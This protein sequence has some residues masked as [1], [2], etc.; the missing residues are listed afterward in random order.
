MAW[1]ELGKLP[2]FSPGPPPDAAR[3]AVQAWNMMSGIDWAALPVVVELLGV[4]DV[5]LLIE[6]LLL[7]RNKQK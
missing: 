5:E 7:I 3:I 2:G 1:I 4:E 6:Q